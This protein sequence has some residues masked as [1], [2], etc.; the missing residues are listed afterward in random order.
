MSLSEI[1]PVNQVRNRIA[2]SPAAPGGST[3][4]GRGNRRGDL[5]PY[6]VAE[7]EMSRC[8]SVVESHRPTDPAVPASYKDARPSRSWLAWL[9]RQV[10]H[11]LC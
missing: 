2:V 11:A 7:H 6:L 4:R 10:V 3:R 8:E 5:Q 9:V 1:L